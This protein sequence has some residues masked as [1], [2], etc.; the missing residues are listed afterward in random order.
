ML[1][2]WYLGSACIFEGHALYACKCSFF[3][4]KKDIYILMLCQYIIAIEGYAPS[5][6]PE[7]KCV[8]VLHFAAYVYTCLAIAD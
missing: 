2:G 5:G 6:G 8:R 7:L 1:Y 3:A 4:H